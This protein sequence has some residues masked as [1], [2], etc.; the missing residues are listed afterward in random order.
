MH[1]NIDRLIDFINMQ[2]KEE[3]GCITNFKALISPTKVQYY[4]DLL[5]F[6]H[7]NN[8]QMF[9]KSIEAWCT[10]FRSIMV[11]ADEDIAKDILLPLKNTRTISTLYKDSIEN[12]HQVRNALEKD[13]LDFFKTVNYEFFLTYAMYYL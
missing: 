3:E 4:E 7:S 13:R 11:Y 6:T 1:L 10:L 8:Y 5:E 12:F 2:T 9:K